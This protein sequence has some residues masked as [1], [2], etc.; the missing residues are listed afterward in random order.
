MLP[1][2]ASD[3]PAALTNL[4]REVAEASFV[5]PA[6][7]ADT[8]QRVRKDILQ[9]LD[10]YIIP[11]YASLDAPLVAVVGGST[12]SGKSTL[13]NSL[14]GR[15]V[16]K[17]SAVRPTTRR[18]VLVHARGERSYFEGDRILPSL[19]RVVGDDVP[20]T[21]VTP[22][23][24]ITEIA[25][26]EAETLPCG[27][28][29]IDSPDIDSVAVENRELATQLLAGADLW[30]FVTTAAR[31][32]DA[33]P[34]EIL[35]E[36]VARNI[37]VAVILNRVPDGVE[38]E[39]RPDLVRR[40]RERGLGSAPLFVIGEHLDDGRIP[41]SVLEPLRGWISGLTSDAAARTSVARQ[42]VAGAV[43]ALLAKEKVLHLALSEQE[44]GVRVLNEAVDEARAQAVE[45]I[46]ASLDNGALLRGEV[47][48]RWQ[49]IAGTGE[50]M[51]KLESGVASLRDR[52]ARWFGGRASVSPEGATD[53][54][55]DSLHS[56]FV[57]EGE[58]A[59]RVLARAWDA[60][61]L[62]L[63]VEQGSRD[64]VMSEEASLAVRDWQ[65]S[66]FRMVEDEGRSKRSLARVLSF[67]VNALG[68]ALMV[69]IFAST[70]G[71]TG[72]E[73]AVAGGTAVV[74]QRVLE[75]VFGDE[76]VRSMAKR[77]RLDLRERARSFV[78]GQMEPF[79]R[80]ADEL[81]A[82][83]GMTTKVAAAF[84]GVASARAREVA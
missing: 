71:L 9:Q 47:M 26:V 53:A 62:P 50:W 25:L 41:Q 18:P 60:Q 40:L 38:Q 75:A 16:S 7:M 20:D 32:A 37:V 78:D 80:A 28:A 39:I 1:L 33:I 79:V 51:K 65:R 2:P 6:S 57:A 73:V 27:L 59:E 63:P 76:A 44:S 14:V 12:G 46:V 56:L 69:V 19:R 22:G 72:G 31:Y 84:A 66:I 48:D 24:P 3:V 67:G 8:G 49:E 36:A 77:A 23:A 45:T 35:G 61:G 17:A 4:R 54:I 11:R 30:I 70:A 81:R 21:S 29:V 58:H 64:A 74:A 42:S 68:V 5:L 82:V 43:D 55:E 52:V 34:W 13:V 10:D 15:V 83:E